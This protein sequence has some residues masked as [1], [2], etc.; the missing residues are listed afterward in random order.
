MKLLQLSHTASMISQF[1]YIM[2]FLQIMV[3]VLNY[4]NSNACHSEV[5]GKVAPTHLIISNACHS[6]S[7]VAEQLQHTTSSIH[8]QN[9]VTFLICL[10]ATPVTLALL[11]VTR[12]SNIYTKDLPQSMFTFLSC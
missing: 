1:T 5:C 11:G 4:N 6:L 9:M 3:T 12:G 2:V 10:L 7:G 8:P